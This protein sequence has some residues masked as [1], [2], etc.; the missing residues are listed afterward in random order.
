MAGERLTTLQALDLL[1]RPKSVAVIGAS[2]DEFSM[3]GA[4]LLNLQLHG[5]E[6]EMFAVNPRRD[7]VNGVASYPSISELPS[8]VDTA[9]IVVSAPQVLGVLP[10]LEKVTRTATIITAGFGVVEGAPS[11]AEIRE[12]IKQSPLRIIGPNTAGLLN[13]NDHYVPRA[14]RN[15]VIDAV[16]GPIALVSQSGALGNTVFCRAQ[17][18]GMPIGLL[19]GTGD[20]MDISV[21][22]AAEFAIRGWH[23]S[24]LMVITEAPI[25]LAQ[26]E[27]LASIARKDGA[28]VVLLKMARSAMAQR[29]AMTH[30]GS[31]A[32]D[33]EVEIAAARAL[34]VTVV[35]DLDELWQVAWLLDRWG[36]PDSPECR[37]GVYCSSGG[38]M[39]ETADVASEL[40]LSLPEG[41]AVN[42]RPAFANPFDPGDRPTPY[43]PNAPRAV[44]STSAFAISLRPVT[45]GLV[46]A[47]PV[48][49][50]SLVS[51]S[52]QGRKAEFQELSEGGR[53]AL[54]MH[55]A[56]SHTEA[57]R[58]SLRETGLPLMEGVRGTLEAVAAWRDTYC[59]EITPRFGKPKENQ[60]PKRLTYWESRSALQSTDCRVAF[61]S[62]IL[63]NSGRDA[64]AAFE[65]LDG[66]VVMK[67]SCSALSHKFNAGLVRLD[68]R[69]AD[70]A[71]SIFEELRAAAM[72]LDGYDGVVCEAK[73]EEGVDLIV[74]GRYGAEFGPLLSIGTG[75]WLAEE[76]KDSQIIFPNFDRTKIIASLKKTTAGGWL[77]RRGTSLDALVE[78]VAC[79][80]QTLLSG[81]VIEFDLNPVRVNP[82]NGLCL[83]LDALVIVSEPLVKN[84]ERNK[85]VSEVQQPT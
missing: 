35:R 54:A 15:H 13:L 36:A 73:S 12:A 77:V 56:G 42:G 44:S 80:G 28:R 33:A 81:R 18:M 65:T 62:A 55:Q 64:S 66:D 45:D 41:E 50:E 63:V 46:Y 67:A 69:S 9:V 74:G 84:S 20:Q 75:G 39:V 60:E 11:R 32:G 59:L 37:I 22:D 21:W 58:Q 8:E 43:D 19:I 16:P 70:R 10:Q 76:V 7:T 27:Q 52:T 29:S 38:L 3:S 5:Y 53:V 2:T 83:A 30:T 48:L 23:A 79:V 78:L 72:D 25:Q 57:L 6:G 47:F 68:V 71:V 14:A 82:A 4:P 26:L 85:S 31:L 61:P 1:T 34:G 24:T 40:G 51:R 49:S 17:A